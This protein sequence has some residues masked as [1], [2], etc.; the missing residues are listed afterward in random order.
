MLLYLF[1]ARWAKDIRSKG[2]KRGL[3]IKEGKSEDL[4]FPSAIS[5]HSFYHRRLTRLGLS[6]FGVPDWIGKLENLEE[7]F[8]KN[9]QLRSF[10]K[11]IWSLK[12][13]WDF[14]V[15][16]KKIESLNGIGKLENLR[17]L[18]I[19][20][21][22]VKSLPESILDLVKLTKIDLS[23][24]NLRSLP[25]L[26]LLPELREFRIK[27]R[28]RLDRHARQVIRRLCLKGVSV[29]IG[30]KRIKHV[31]PVIRPEEKIVYGLTVADLLKHAEIKETRY[32]KYTTILLAKMKELENAKKKI[33]REV[34]VNAIMTEYVEIFE[35]LRQQG[36]SRKRLK[37][38]FG[39]KD[40]QSYLRSV[41]KKLMKLGYNVRKMDVFAGLPRPIVPQKVGRPKQEQKRKK[42]RPKKK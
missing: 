22:S 16:C 25:D 23:C 35:I 4:Y 3:V 36:L 2:F 29:K 15:I 10:P 8:I 28:E 27:H 33:T 31:P 24:P 14:S 40:P 19:D 17:S 26:S 13:L 42:R 7:L 41:K 11:D 30:F 12:K 9:D 37:D 6:G 18:S 38:V 34:L 20:S 39:Y 32:E 5:E 1:P 21:Q